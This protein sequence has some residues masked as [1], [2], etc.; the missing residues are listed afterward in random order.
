MHNA[1]LP[2]LRTPL[3][4][5]QRGITRGLD[6]DCSIACNEGMPVV[7]VCAASKVE[8]QPVLATAGV[9]SQESGVRHSPF[10]NARILSVGATIQGCN[11]SPLRRALRPDYYWDSPSPVP[12]GRDTL[13]RKGERAVIQLRRGGGRCAVASSSGH[14]RRPAPGGKTRCRARDW[15]VWG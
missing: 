5:G 9:S 10:Q 15:A 8:A 4:W 14:G 3:P 12:T 11:Q 6:H 2:C 7:D 13:S 1:G